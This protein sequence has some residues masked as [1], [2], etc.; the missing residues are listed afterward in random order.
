MLGCGAAA[1]GEG[2]IGSD[3]SSVE[4]I[5]MLQERPL[6]GEADSDCQ[7]DGGLVIC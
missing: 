3:R 6:P 2:T 1:L 4:E 5:V 7:K